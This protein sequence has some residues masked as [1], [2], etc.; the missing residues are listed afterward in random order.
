[1]HIKLLHSSKDEPQDTPLLGPQLQCCFLK[2]SKQTPK[3]FFQNALV[4]RSDYLSYLSLIVILR[5]GTIY[6]WRKKKKRCFFFFF[7]YLKGKE[8]TKQPSK[9]AVF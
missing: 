8:T 5:P 1:M 3:A 7:L 9:K 4:L 2:A 6:N